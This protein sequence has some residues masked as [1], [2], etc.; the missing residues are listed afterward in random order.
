MYHIPV[1]LFIAVIISIGMFYFEIKLVPLFSVY[2]L[3]DVSHRLFCCTA[4]INKKKET[5]DSMIDKW[6]I[7]H[8]SIRLSIYMSVWTG[9]FLFI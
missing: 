3:F 5:N 7:Y 1:F 9:C 8:L 6:S 2:I 4:T